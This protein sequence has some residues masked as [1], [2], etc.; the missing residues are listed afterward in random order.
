MKFFDASFVFGGIFLA[1]RGKDSAGDILNFC[2]AIIVERILSGSLIGSVLAYSYY[3]SADFW[4]K[5]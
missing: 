1:K 3:L 2:R 5:L 4:Q